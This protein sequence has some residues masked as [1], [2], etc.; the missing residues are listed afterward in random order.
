LGFAGVDLSGIPQRTEGIQDGGQAFA[1]VRGE[2]NGERDEGGYSAPP[3]SPSVLVA[4]LGR[5]AESDGPK[6][7]TCRWGSG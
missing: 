4:M 7:I 1:F 6:R 3:E 2:I 5:P